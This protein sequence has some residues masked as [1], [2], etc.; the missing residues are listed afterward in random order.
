MYDDFMAG[1][2]GVR[3][4][5][6]VPVPIAD[7]TS[8]SYSITGQQQEYRAQ[9]ADKKLRTQQVSTTYDKSK[10]TRMRGPAGEEGSIWANGKMYIILGPG[11]Q[12]VRTFPS[13]PFAI[14]YMQQ[15]G[16]TLV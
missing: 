11:K 1:Y 2:N 14:K 5:P 4:K 9:Q 6:R 16:W 3:P 7:A 10:F 13:R 15:K 8:R 12:Q